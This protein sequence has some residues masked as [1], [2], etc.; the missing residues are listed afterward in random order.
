MRINATEIAAPF[1]T[2]IQRRVAEM[3]EQGFP[4]PKLVGLLGNKDPAAK[5]YAQWTAQACEA[6]G[7]RYELREMEREDLQTRLKEAIDDPEVHGIIVYY[8]VYGPLPHFMGTTV[9]DFICNSVP[10][11]KDVEGM[12]FT[13][14]NNLYRNIRH[15]DEE[16]TKKCLVPCTALSIVKILE[17]LKVYDSALPV[18]D[19][20][21]GTTITIVNRSDIVGRPLAAMLSNDGATVYSVDIKSTFRLNRGEYLECEEGAEE[22][23]KKSSVIITGV[24][25]KAYRLPLDCVQDNSIVVNFS[26][27]KNVDPAALLEKRG[28]RYVPLVGKVTVAMLE[29]NLLRLYENFAK[30]IR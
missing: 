4:A 17:H 29:R 16:K 15:L 1:R 26:R 19:R 6:D 2:E 28:I 20:L 3:T 11:S 23:I 24:P 21:S 12:C 9:D 27:Y 14:R 18:G 30:R 10:V 7:L 5:K 25:S 13:Y 22:A 8:P